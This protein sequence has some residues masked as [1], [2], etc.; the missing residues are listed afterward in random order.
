VSADRLPLLSAAW[1]VARRDFVAILWSRSFIFF[2]LGP[3]FPLIV[4][5]LAGGI[6]QR[7]ESAAA[8]PQIGIAMRGADVD[9]MVA[10]RATLATQLGTTI[11]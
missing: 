2:L 4:G 6:G 10:A 5:G 7:V 3:L 11:P 9:R 1:V 8:V